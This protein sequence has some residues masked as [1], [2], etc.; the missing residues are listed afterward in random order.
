MTRWIAAACLALA[1][2]AWGAQQAKP[3]PIPCAKHDDVLASLKR[4]YGE[5]I[6]AVGATKSNNLIELLTSEEGTFSIILVTPKGHACLI[7]SGDGW[8]PA[9]KEEH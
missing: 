9:R 2:V 6:R 4:L 5:E 7:E 8:A 3:H 1:F